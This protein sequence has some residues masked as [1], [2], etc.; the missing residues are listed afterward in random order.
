MSVITPLCDRDQLIVYMEKLKTHGCGPEVMLGKLDAFESALSFIS[1]FIL[2]DD[3][4][5]TLHGQC[6]R[7]SETMKRWR[8]TLRK[9]KALTREIR[10][11]KLSVEK[12]SLDE[13]TA[14]MKVRVYGIHSC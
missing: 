5:N 7:M 14:M 2:K 12:L 9:Q 3:D 8:S 13:I 10:L 1:L 11:E 4:T 6:L